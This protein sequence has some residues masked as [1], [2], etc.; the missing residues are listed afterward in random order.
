LENNVRFFVEE[1][2]SPQGFQILVDSNRAFS[3][4]A[5]AALPDLYDIM[6][7]KVAMLVHSFSVTSHS[8]LAHLT[9]CTSEM[10][11]DG[12]QLVHNVMVAPGTFDS[13]NKFSTNNYFSSA[14]LAMAV[15][16]WAGTCTKFDEEYSLRSLV[17]LMSPIGLSRTQLMAPIV[18][19][20]WMDCSSGLLDPTTLYSSLEVERGPGLSL[21]G[22]EMPNAMYQYKNVKL[23]APSSY[24]EPFTTE[25]YT[26]MGQRMRADTSLGFRNQLCSWSS[27][28]LHDDPEGQEVLLNLIPEE[29]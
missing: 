16:D 9:R 6:G 14:T 3:G 11:L 13:I 24:L 10:K 25:A 4:I 28:F 27:Q 23:S 22:F 19:N 7:P 18:C 20:G 15:D 1:C 21:S 17:D 29:A 2:D 12:G 5:A 26:P 8:N